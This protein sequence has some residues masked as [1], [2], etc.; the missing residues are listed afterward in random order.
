MEHVLPDLYE[1]AFSGS[2]GFTFAL[3]LNCIDTLAGAGT[4]VLWHSG[5]SHAYLVL[6][7]VGDVIFAAVYI[8]I[9]AI[10]MRW[11]LSITR[12]WHGTVPPCLRLSGKLIVCIHAVEVDP[13][14]TG[15]RRSTLGWCWYSGAKS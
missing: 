5:S 12:T 6:R 8:Y 2:L 11:N 13:L 1:F 10:K 14:P 9:V 15:H 7:L 3:M 4:C